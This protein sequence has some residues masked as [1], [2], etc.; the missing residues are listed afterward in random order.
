MIFNTEIQSSYPASDIAKAREYLKELKFISK[1]MVALNQ[2]NKDALLTVFIGEDDKYDIAP[3]ARE[4]QAK[5]LEYVNVK[6]EENSDKKSLISPEAAK[7]SKIAQELVALNQKLEKQ[8]PQEIYSQ[9]TTKYNAL[10]AF[11]PSS[12]FMVLSN[13][14]EVPILAD[15][16][17]LKYSTVLSTP[18][19][20]GFKKISVSSPTS[21][22]VYS[23]LAETFNNSSFLV[24][25]LKA[26]SASAWSKYTNGRSIPMSVN[27]GLFLLTIGIH[28]LYKLEHRN[29]TEELVETPLFKDV[30]PNWKDT[31][32]MN[33]WQKFKKYDLLKYDER[34]K[35]VQHEAINQQELRDQF[36]QFV[37]EWFAAGNTHPQFDSAEELIKTIED[38]YNNLKNKPG[39]WNHINNIILDLS[40]KKVFKQT[41]TRLFVIAFSPKHTFAK[42][43]DSKIFS[44]SCVASFLHLEANPS[45]NMYVMLRH[46]ADP[47]ADI[48]LITSLTGI[49]HETW[50]RY[51]QGTRIPHSAAWTAILMALDIHPIY[52]VVKRTDQKEMKKAFEVYKEIHHAFSS[53]KSE[54]KLDQNAT[55]EDFLA[56]F[57]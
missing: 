50:I 19:I 25:C 38:Y 28:P 30:F 51:E 39:Y 1:P 40:N 11:Y 16:D 21:G 13:K 27:W 35:T 4:I 2:Q 57:R 24:H 42:D 6:S 12:D 48:H 23:Y 20:K 9:Y 44:L 56:E 47:N 7:K 32:D 22:L 8:L 54:F 37:T 33:A 29:N 34:N 17:C 53:D 18:T 36:K 15:T 14:G 3:L 10:A 5:C 52:K 26:S 49:S 41:F 31:F 45:P 46:L 43:L 55:F